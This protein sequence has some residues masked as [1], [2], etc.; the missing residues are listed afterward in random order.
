MRSLA[1]RGRGVLIVYGPHGIGKSTL[2]RYILA[3][4]LKEREIRAVLDLSSKSLGEIKENF[5]IL[6]VSNTLHFTIPHLW[7][8]T[9]PATKGSP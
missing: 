7:K 8:F 1:E 9:S 2:V 6:R 4:L 3:K 5:T